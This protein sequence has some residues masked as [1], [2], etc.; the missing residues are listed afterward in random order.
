MRERAADPLAPKPRPADALP[1]DQ[2]ARSREKTAFVSMRARRDVPPPPR[3]ASADL[4]APATAQAAR[5]SIRPVEADRIGS[6]DAPDPGA[7]DSLTRV[8][9]SPPP[10]AP[11][12]AKA[13]TPPEVQSPR[14]AGVFGKGPEPRAPKP[15]ARSKDQPIGKA[16]FAEAELPHDTPPAPPLTSAPAGTAIDSPALAEALPGGLED[17]GLRPGMAAATPEKPTRTTM[18]RPSG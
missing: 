18:A 3:P 7:L 6:P 1:K 11:S 8:R 9:P 14:A 17:A 15:A 2:P 10:P 12:V 16:A 4:R 13:P 5:L